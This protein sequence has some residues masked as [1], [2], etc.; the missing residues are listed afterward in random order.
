MNRV[1][2]G[3]MVFGALLGAITLM[4]GNVTVAG[5]KITICHAKSSE[6]NPFVEITISINGWEHGHHAQHEDDYVGK[7]EVLTSSLIV[8]PTAVA[9]S[10]AQS[11][12]EIE[13]ESSTQFPTQLPVS[14]GAPK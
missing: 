9:S 2:T 6:T 13:V 5:E 3:L 4:S 11:P 8:T 12:E 1:F 10:I 14:G 7:C